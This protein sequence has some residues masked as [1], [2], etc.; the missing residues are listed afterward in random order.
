MNKWLL[1][2]GLVFWV[3]VAQAQNQDLALLRAHSEAQHSHTEEAAREKTGFRPGKMLLNGALTVYQSLFSRQ[4][5]TQCIYELSCSRF[6][7]EAVKT[8]G[9]LKAI[10][11]S[12]D[13]I[14]RC[15][16]IHYAETSKLQQ[17]KEGKLVDTPDRYTLRQ[18]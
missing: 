6:S 10:V 9:P 5:S 7:R 1:L 17:N 2:C 8:W 3:G 4:L 12:A 15:N 11:L 13:R 18:P 14:T 16:R